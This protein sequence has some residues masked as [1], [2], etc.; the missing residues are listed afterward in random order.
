MAFKIGF[1]AEHEDAAPASVSNFVPEKT[2]V[3]R[4]S[5]VQVYFPGRDLTLAYYNDRF[6]LH[7][8]DIVYV[9]GKLE[10]QQGRVV[11]VSYNF[12]IKASQYMQVLSVVDTT[13]HGRFYMGGMHF[14]TF[15]PEA[16]PREQAIT[17]FRPPEPEGDVFL[18]GENEDTFLL[19]DLAGMQVSAVVGERGK[20]YYIENRVKYICLDGTCGYAIVEGS[21]A[22][23]V[24][25]QYV[26]GEIR[27]LTCIC[28][29][30]YN[31]K[32][33]VAAMLQLK[34]VLSIIETQYA[35]Q[36]EASGYFAA[37]SRGILFEYAVGSKENGSF[38][39]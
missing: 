27:G 35:E 8:G 4:R 21:E 13:V 14:L 25:F 9:Q 31:C 12:K 16:L 39:L 37:V 34:K 15:E 33:E 5:V 30:S 38:T 18:V 7:I 20:E 10:G 2:D 22:Y 29:C 19:D 1:T 23:E 17:W 28:P 36:Y 26:S 6:D 24:E 11:S 32:H 3:P